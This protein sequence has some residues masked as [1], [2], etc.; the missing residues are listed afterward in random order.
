M[1]NRQ[2]SIISKLKDIL[3]NCGFLVS[4]G[5]YPDDAADIGTYPAVLVMDGDESNYKCL[6]GMGVEFEYLVSLLLLL[7]TTH[8]TRIKDI[9]DLQNSIMT[10]V[11]TSD[12]LF[13][14][15][16]AVGLRMVG[17]AKGDVNT[18]SGLDALGY[19]PNLTVRRI[20]FMFSVQDDNL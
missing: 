8:N 16:G 20:D 13:T 15:A 17:V 18:M 9:L 3:D 12:D 7:D 4:V 2:W 14:D 5:Y 1:H 6:T 10:L 11:A 19:L